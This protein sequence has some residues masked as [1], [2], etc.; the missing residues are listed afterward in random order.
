MMSENWTLKFYGACL[1]YPGI[2]VAV[3]K[4]YCSGTMVFFF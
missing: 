2:T 3:K 4:L 1:K